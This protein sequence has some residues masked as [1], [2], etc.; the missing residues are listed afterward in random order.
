MIAENG[1]QRQGQPRGNQLAMQQVLAHAR[2][3]LSGC[4]SV[5]ELHEVMQILLSIRRGKRPGPNGIPGVAY[6]LAACF[7]ADV[8]G[9]ALADL[10]RED[11]EVPEEFH[12]S[13]WIPVGKKHNPTSTKDIRDLEL[14]HEDRK[15]LSRMVSRLLDEAGNDSLH[16]AQQAFFSSRDILKNVVGFNDKFYDAHERQ[17]LR[18]FL[19]LDC[20]KGYNMMSWGFLRD[21][22]SKAMLCLAMITAV[23]NLVMG[24]VA[25]LCMAGAVHQLLC[26]QCG[27]GQGDPLS[28][29]L[30]VLA[31]D[32]LLCLLDTLPGVGSLFAFCDD[33]QVEVLDVAAMANVQGMFE[34]FELASGQV[35]NHI[36]SNILT[37]LVPSMADRAMLL[38][39]WPQCCIVDRMKILSVWVGQTV[40]PAELFR[41]VLSDM[42]ERSHAFAA[43]P[44][45]LATKVMASNT[46][47][48]S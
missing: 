24:A 27:L 34:V 39:W 5:L 12:E 32:A 45:S 43:A 36:K 30:Y 15:I 35:V 16:S 46:S 28:C 4:R 41:D 2:L 9:E 14:P 20:S 40:E 17:I 3:D 18:A 10:Q 37:T 19:C 26:W 8:F 11:H 21:V 1:R 31:V 7:L 44:M 38:P 48:A 6:K 47:L 29:F 23:M 13:L 25:Y 33:W 22:L 42:T